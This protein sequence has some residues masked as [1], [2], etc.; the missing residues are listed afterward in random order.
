MPAVDFA[1]CDVPRSQQSPEQHSR[2]FRRGYNG[3]SFDPALELLVQSFDCIRG[4]DR[5][6]LALGEAREGEELIASLFQTGG[7]CGA[8]QP[9]LAK[10]C[11]RLATQPGM[12][13]VTTFSPISKDTT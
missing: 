1:H 13:P 4:P 8:F 7:P 3:L 10:S 6:P 12:P 2:R 5:F 9:P 11:T